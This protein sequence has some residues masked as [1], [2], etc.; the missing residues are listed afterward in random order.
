MEKQEYLN[1]FARILDIDADVASV[2][3][4]L[5]LLAGCNFEAGS[6]AD[7]ELENEIRGLFSEKKALASVHDIA[8]RCR[9]HTNQNLRDFGVM[10]YPFTKEGRY[11]ILFNGNGCSN[12]QTSEVVS[13]LKHLSFQ[14]RP[15]LA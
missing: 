11:G 7:Q 12:I 4:Y 13:L 3:S 10:L 9:D 2:K 1:P 8:L 14:N 6:Q 5:L 15:R